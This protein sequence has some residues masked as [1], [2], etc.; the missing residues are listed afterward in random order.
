MPCA[1]AYLPAGR[2]Y[3][4]DTGSDPPM[5]PVLQDLIASGL[6]HYSYLTNA[7]KE[8]Q[9]EP[10]APGRSFNWQVQMASSLHVQPLA[11][12]QT[13]RCLAW[14]QRAKLHACLVALDGM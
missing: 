12:D 1:P 6:V 2:F 3:V 9:L 7:T 13:C 5:E 4:F 8:V 14:L 11:V 10:P